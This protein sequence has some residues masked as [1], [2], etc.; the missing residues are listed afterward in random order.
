MLLVTSGFAHTHSEPPPSFSPPPHPPPF[1]LI[2]AKNAAITL[3]GAVASLE[4]MTGMVRG[5]RKP[6]TN[7]QHLIQLRDGLMLL[8]VP[9]VMIDDRTP[10]LE[11]VMCALQYVAGCC[12][13]LQC[14][15]VCCS[16]VHSCQIP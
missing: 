10:L 9:N 4:V 12:R 3:L 1:S 5:L 13:V 15:A 2:Q 11:L 16:V 14:V 7:S 8:H 6:L